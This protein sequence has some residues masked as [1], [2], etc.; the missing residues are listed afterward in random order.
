MSEPT[1]Q[2]AEAF[3]MQE[4]TRL[5]DEVLD[6]THRVLQRRFGGSYTATEWAEGHMTHEEIRELMAEIIREFNP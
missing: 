2:E 1:R 4:L 5:V 3:V 6:A